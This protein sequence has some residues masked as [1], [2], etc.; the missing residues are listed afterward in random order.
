VGRKGDKDVKKGFT[1]TSGSDLDFVEKIF[2]IQT[3]RWSSQRPE[4]FRMKKQIG[5]TIVC[6]LSCTMAQSKVDLFAEFKKPD[7]ADWLA[8]AREELQGKDPEQALSWQVAGLQVNAL[9]SRA[10]CLN[11]SMPISTVSSWQNIPLITVTDPAKGNNLALAH[12]NQGADGILFSLSHATGCPLDIL[13]KKIEWPHCTISFLL[14]EPHGFFPASLKEY[15]AEKKYSA[16]EITGSL[17]I[18]T[19]AHHPQT[20][21]NIIHNLVA[22]TH[23]DCL[24]IYVPAGY[25]ADRI[26]A[27]LAQAAKLVTQL[28][29]TGMSA[30]VALNRISFAVETGPDIFIEIATLRALRFLWFQVVRAYGVLDYEPTDLHLHAIST[31]WVHPE[32]EPHSNMLKSTTAA[33]AA[34]IGGCNALSVLPENEQDDRLVRIARNVSILLKEESRFDKVADPLAGSFYLE[35]LTCQLAEKAWTLFQQKMADS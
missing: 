18:K 16:H 17:F 13:L 2:V 9:Y 22:L 10:Q 26:A 19:Y 35:S 8:V 33:M 34:V 31:P 15:I 27:S 7:Y 25:P 24:G 6:L 14:D 4:F 30:H 23:F 3:N 28:E 5:Q 1:K 29:G 21:N 12:L 20:I 32:L 11:E